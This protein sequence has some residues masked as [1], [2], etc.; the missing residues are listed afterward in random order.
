MRLP[1]LHA[2]RIFGSQENLQE[3]Y[4]LHIP[5][6]PLKNYFKS[7]LLLVITNFKK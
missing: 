3:D 7:L 6:E 1:Q 5:Q 2:V 4:N